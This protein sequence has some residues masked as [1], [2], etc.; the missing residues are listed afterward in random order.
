VPFSLVSP[1]PFI[2]SEAS[3]SRVIL[4]HHNI[5]APSSK[6]NGRSALEAAAENSRPD[7]VQLLLNA[8]EIQSQRLDRPQ[9]EKARQYSSLNGHLEV[10]EMLRDYESQHVQIGHVHGK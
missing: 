3:S 1:A 9:L 7:T 4:L 8:R 2:P 6:A 10:E 5:N